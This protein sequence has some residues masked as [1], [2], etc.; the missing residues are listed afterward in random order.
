MAGRKR[1]PAHCLPHSGEFDN[2]VTDHEV[3]GHPAE[4]PNQGHDEDVR[5]PH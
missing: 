2:G 4:Y 3:H 1:G 5:M